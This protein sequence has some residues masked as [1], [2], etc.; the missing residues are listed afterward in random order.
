M[1]QGLFLQPQVR[2][3]IHLSRF[4]G[5][6]PKPECDDRSVDTMTE[7]L[8]RGTVSQHVG[9][10]AFPLQ[11]STALGRR[12]GVASDEPFDRISAE[13][14]PPDAGEERLSGRAGLSA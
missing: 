12:R 5:F 10:D 8:H 4:H 2:V 9:R 3:E 11:R 14:T 13:R 7:K 1:G 6:M